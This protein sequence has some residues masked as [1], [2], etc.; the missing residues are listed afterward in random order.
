MDAGD[1]QAPELHVLQVPH[2]VEERNVFGQHG[3]VVGFQV[4]Q[5]EPDLLAFVLQSRFSGAFDAVILQVGGE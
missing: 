5:E 2:D 4:T 1:G 3:V